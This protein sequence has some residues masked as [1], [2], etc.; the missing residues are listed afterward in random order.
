MFQLE[1]TFV[2]VDLENV[3]GGSVHVP[4]RHT[5]VLEAV[6]SLSGASECL[7]VYSTGPQA[8]HLA[9]DLLWKWNCARYVPGRGIDGADN[10]LIEVLRAEPVATRSSRVLLFSGDH[11]FTRTV[12]DL[13][14]KNIHTTVVSRPQSISREL[15]AAADQLCLLPNFVGSSPSSPSSLNT[16]LW[17]AA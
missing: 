2:I 17:E 1:R 16:N 7:I 10:A 4:G 8:L 13:S 5:E 14:A 3:C 9:P 11:A 15:A 6:R 12:A